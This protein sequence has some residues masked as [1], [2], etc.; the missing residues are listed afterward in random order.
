MRTPRRMRVIREGAFENNLQFTRVILGDE[1]E[2]IGDY[3]FRGCSD[4]QSIYLPP[5]VKTIGTGAFDGCGQLVVTCHAG[6][7]AEAYCV[8]QALEYVLVDE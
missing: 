3:A 5:S 4:L 1:V 2:T 8:E 6:S 7:A